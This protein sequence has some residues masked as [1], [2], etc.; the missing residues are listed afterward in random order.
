MYEQFYGLREK[1]F[2]LTPNPRYVFYSHQYH[3]AAGQ[4]IYG[5]NNR[6]GFMLVT[7]EPGTGKT[8]LCRDLIEK[9]DHDK[10]QSALIFNPFLNGMEM[11][12]VLLTEFGIVVPPGA[13]RKELLDRLN[14]F[15]LAQLA[16][17][18]SCVAIFDEAQHLAPEFLEQIR[19]LSNLETEQ[20]KLIQIILVGQPE[21]L[22]KIR[23]PKMAQLQ[24]RVSIRCTLRDLTE[25]ETDRYI[26]HRLNVAGAHGQVHFSPRAVKEVF[27]GSHGV[28]RLINLISD[29]AL[30]AGYS[31]Q[32]NDIQ[33]DHVFKAI[34][35]LRGEDAAEVRMRATPPRGHVR[36]R[37]TAVASVAAI[38][39][40]GI[41][42]AGVALWPRLRARTPDDRLYAQTASAAN[43]AD[44]ERNLVDFVARYPNSEHYGE[45]MIKL[46]RLEMSRGDRA[47]AIQRLTQF[48][49][50]VPTG[51]HHASAMVL[52]A[53]ARL[54]NGDTTAACQGITPDLPSA[55]ADDNTLSDQLTAM[56]SLCASRPAAS[57]D[58]TPR[59]DSTAGTKSRKS[60]TP[61]GDRKRPP[62]QSRSIP[63]NSV[64]P[65]P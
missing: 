39:L 9:L 52:I 15:L 11:L 2:A 46:A 30:L 16:L 62:A 29:R 38:G 65:K 59:R 23:A 33:P 27:R 41:A 24:Q 61:A 48:A 50:Q 31:A 55:V 45:A 32:T 5:I 64:G 42:A 63:P 12:A 47:G 44:V 13:T 54:D 20:E 51:I 43:D 60:T 40:V 53:Q 19:V 8:T 49:E 7:G 17:G 6:E 22:T 34:G 1:P 28:P 56:S 35:A 18:K 37:G 57:D 21:L 26:H 4:L 58:A 36:R 25:E 10:C 14:Q 3:E